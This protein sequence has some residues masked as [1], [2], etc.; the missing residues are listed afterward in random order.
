MVCEQVVL[1]KLRIELYFLIWKVNNNNNN[2]N[3]VIIII[4]IILLF[5]LPYKTSK[6]T[7]NKILKNK[8]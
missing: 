8:I 3:N 1:I 2:N 4:I 7:Y 6:R 5:F